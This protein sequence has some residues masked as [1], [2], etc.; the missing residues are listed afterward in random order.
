[1]QL[2][3]TGE[4][5]WVKIIDVLDYDEAIGSNGPFLCIRVE[6]ERGPE[7]YRNGGNTIMFRAPNNPA[8]GA[9]VYKRGEVAPDSCS[10]VSISTR[11]ERRIVGRV[12]CR[13]G[14]DTYLYESE[15]EI[16]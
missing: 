8:A 3:R 5:H 1:M 16:R 15:R 14:V 13:I 6:E 2:F 12:W 9:A 7:F 11:I 4:S 10:I